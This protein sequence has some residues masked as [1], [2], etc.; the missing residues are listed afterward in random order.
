MTD[1]GVD[2]TKLV[3]AVLLSTILT[4]ALILGLTV[5]YYRYQRSVE[6]S[7][8]FTEPPRKLQALRASQIERLT[9]YRNV[10]VEKGIVAIPIDRAMELVVAELARSEAG[11]TREG[12][13]ER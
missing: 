6:T 12:G 9:T 13:D 4:V 3:L 2:T 5:V 10:D 8:K 7:R 1:Y 11:E